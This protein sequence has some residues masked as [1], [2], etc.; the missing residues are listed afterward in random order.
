MYYQK[1]KGPKTLTG[2][3]S[4]GSF[5]SM[6]PKVSEQMQAILYCWFLLL[7]AII[8]RRKKHQPVVKS[9]FSFFFFFLLKLVMLAWRQVVASLGVNKCNNSCKQNKVGERNAKWPLTETC[10]HQKLLTLGC[11]CKLIPSLWYKWGGYTLWAFS[12]NCNV[13]LKYI[14]LLCGLQDVVSIMMLWPH[15]SPNMFIPLVLCLNS[16]AHSFH[17][18]FSYRNLYC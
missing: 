9:M 4:K 14:C 18:L 3:L 16:L 2:W 11:T 5:R 7:K 10:L 12:N 1:T 6:S 13:C 15:S 8:I 17:I